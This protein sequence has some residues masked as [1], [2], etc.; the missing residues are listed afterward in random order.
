MANSFFRSFVNMHPDDFVRLSTLFY[1]CILRHRDSNTIY[2]VLTTGKK[3]FEKISQVW[4]CL[5]T[6]FNAAMKPTHLT[7]SSWPKTTAL[8]KRLAPV[9]LSL[10]R[11]NFFLDRCRFSSANEPVSAA[12]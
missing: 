7:M 2:E 6:S 1:E 8:C 10:A 12:R 3:R 5:S 11:A 9:H 4:T